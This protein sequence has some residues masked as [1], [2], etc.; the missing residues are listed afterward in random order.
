MI[1]VQ[2]CY[3]TQSQYTDTG[4]TSSGTGPATPGT[5]QGRHFSTWSLVWLQQGQE[6]V[7]PHH[8]RSMQWNEH[9][10]GLVVKAFASRAADPRFDS[11]LRLDF[12]KRSHTSDLKI[13]SPVATLPGAWRNRVGTG[14]GWPSVSIPQKVWSATSVV[15]WQH[16]QL[17]EQICPWYTNMLLGCSATNQ[18]TNKQAVE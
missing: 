2:T 18:P 9:L 7:I 13:G 1:E 16:V 3:L 15:V 12:S 10:V 6:E 11:C 8:E 4:L 14:T 17:S 5:Q